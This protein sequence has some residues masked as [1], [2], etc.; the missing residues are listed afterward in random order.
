[1]EE[2]VP[3]RRPI[4]EG[5]GYFIEDR[6]TGVVPLHELRGADA[7]VHVR[8]IA[9][10]DEPGG[11]GADAVKAGADRRWR[12]EL[13]SLRGLKRAIQA[14]ALARRRGTNWFRVIVLRGFGRVDRRRVAQRIAADCLDG[15]K[16]VARPRV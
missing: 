15:T 5:P 3:G 6:E 9:R 7:A 10:W 11:A 14:A 1:M 2:R 8:R 4:F 16:F 13:L 12:G